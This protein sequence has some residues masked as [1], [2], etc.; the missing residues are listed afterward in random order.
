MRVRRS[1]RKHPARRSSSY[2]PFLLLGVVRPQGPPKS[3]PLVMDNP[4]YHLLTS[5]DPVGPP[6]AVAG[7][8]EF[9]VHMGEMSWQ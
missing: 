7:V 1:V 2:L 5:R 6:S 3:H 4:R 9:L 8:E